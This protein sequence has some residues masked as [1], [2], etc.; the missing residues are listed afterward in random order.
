MTEA[1]DALLSIGDPARMAAA[2]R[3]LAVDAILEA[4]E[5]HQGVPLGMAEIATA[6]YRGHI[7]FDP[8]DPLWPDRDRF[9]LSNGHGSMLLYALLCLTGYEKIPLDEVKRF[10]RLGSHCAGHPEY[11]P[12][13]GIETTT[14]PLGQ[15]IANAV[16]MAIAEEHL[17]ARFGSRLVDHRVWAF[18]GDGCLQEGVGQEAISLAG[19]LRLG[20]LTFVW[21]DNRITDDGSTDLSISEDV[22]ERFR[23]AGWHVVEVD[24][25]DVDAVSSTFDEAERD[26][27]PSLVACRTVIARGIPR[28]EGRRGGHS[29]PVFPEDRAAMAAMFGWEGG[30]F[31]I[32]ADASDSW[33]AAGLYG[34]SEREA[35]TARLAAADPVLRDEFLRSVAGRPASGEAGALSSVRRKAAVSAEPSPLIRSSG[36]AAAALCA[37]APDVIVGCAD[38]EA[39]TN[40]KRELP[41]FSAYDRA[42]RYI[43]C[44]VREHLMA[45]LSNGIAA[46]GG[47]R[48]VAVTY[49]AFADYQRA[50]MRMAALMKLPVVFVFSHDSIGIGRNGPTHQPVEIIASLRAMPDMTVIRPADAVEAAEAWEIAAAHREGP[51]SLIFARQAVPRLRTDGTGENRTRRGAYV[52][53]DAEGDRDV[54]LLA[55]GSEVAIAAEARAVLA[56]RGIRAA[57]VSMPCWSLF[58]RQEPAYRASVLGPEGGVRVGIE[59]GMK[60]GWERWLG[61]DGPFVGMNGFGASGSAED[62]Y[63]HFGI[64]AEATADAAQ[65]ALERKRR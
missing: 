31:E 64:T 17:R 37:V 57:V 42:G 3:F 50:S 53:E 4:G 5:G 21:D 47:A 62:L 9:V 33:K 56:T 15:G 45:A 26:P 38:L 27:R 55:T 63:R 8:T 36:D 35:W 11:D 22:A 25:H 6:L 12:A 61:F 49:L 43:H 46:H 20:R 23:V 59:A 58:E 54:T 16:G 44:G 28:L 24:G 65:A 41:A 40:H 18:V 29:A 30:R 19:H 48:P 32:P 7:K 60:F 2:I 13:A 51:L 1:T 10:R 39:P 52:L 14:G 34:R